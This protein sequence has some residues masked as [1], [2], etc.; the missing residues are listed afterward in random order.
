MT[1]TPI[2]VHTD[3]SNNGSMKDSIN[4]VDTLIKRMKSIGITS[5]AVTDHG[6]MSNVVNAYK[7]SAKAGIK[8]IPGY[9]GYLTADLSIQQRD[10]QHITLWAKDNIGYRNLNVISKH[11]C[12]NNGQDPG[13]YYYKPRVDIELLRKYSEGLMVG[14]ACL[15]GWLGEEILVK[16]IDIFGKDNVFLEIHT[17]QGEGQS[18]HNELA[19]YLAK[20]YDVLPVVATDAHFAFKDDFELWKLFKNTSKEVEGNETLGNTLY[21]Q[22]VDEIKAS[23]SYLPSHIVEQAIANTNVIAEKSNV[24]IDFSSKHYPHFP[25]DDE[26]EAVRGKCKDKWQSIVD[27]GLD[28][29]VYGE[30][31]KGEL[32]VLRYQDYCG[33]FLITGDYME[34]A[35]SKGIPLGPGRGSACGS[36]VAKLCNITKLD[37]VALDLTF[38]RFAHN[39]RLAPPDIDVDITPNGRS[40]I[41]EYLREKYGE[42]YQ[43]RTFGT[44]ACSGA[45]RL[46]GKSLGLDNNY[47]D[48]VAKSLTKYESDDEDDDI[49]SYDQK[50]WQLDHIRTEEN[51]E[52]IDIA[53]RF[54]GICVGYGK[55]AS[56]VIILDK[57]IDDFCAI[58]RQ[59]DSK[60]KQPTYIAACEYP[61]LEAQGLMKA[62]LLG[63]KAL[64]VIDD[65]VKAVGG[66]DIDAIPLDDPKTSAMLCEGFTQACFQIES[67][68]M[69]HLVKQIRPQSFYDLI[70]LVAL[71]RPGPLNAIVEPIANTDTLRKQHSE[72]LEQWIS[73][74]KTS[75]ES[76]Q[77][78]A[79]RWNQW[80][81]NGGTLSP[82]DVKKY[83]M[84]QT[85]IGV[86]NWTELKQWTNKGNTMESWEHWDAVI[87]DELIEPTYLYES[88]RSILEPTYSIVL[89]QE[90]IMEIAKQL[91]G[92]TLGEAD[93]L[94]RI[95]GKKKVDEM[96]PALNAMI[97]RGVNN[98]IPKDVMEAIATQIVEFAMYCFNKCMAGDERLHRPANGSFVP[99][100]KEMWLIKNDKEYAKSTGHKDLHSKYNTYGY[101]TTLSMFDDGNI[102]KN[103]VIDI[104]PSGEAAIYRVTTATGKVVDCTMNHKFPTP[105]GERVLY[106][107]A[108]GDSLYVIGDYEITAKIYNFYNS[109]PPPSN[110]PTAG[111]QG[112]Q[113]NPYG[114]SALFDTAREFYAT[115]KAP[116]EDCGTGTARKYE[117]HHVNMNRQDNSN[118]NLRWLCVSCHRKTHYAMGRTK[119]GTRGS[120]AVI[121]TIT[122][123]EYLRTD[124]VFDVTMDAPNH[125]FVN[126]GGVV[127][128]NSHSAAYG[129]LAYQTAHLKANYQREYLCAMINSEDNSHKDIIPYIKECKKLGIA[130]LPPDITKLNREWAIEG[131]GL[132]MGLHYIKGVGDN[133]RLDDVSSYEAVKSLNNKGVCAAL[134]KSGALD[135]FGMSRLSMLV[136]VMQTQQGITKAYSAV[137]KNHKA[138]QRLTADNAARTTEVQRNTKVYAE[139]QRKIEKYTKDIPRLQSKLEEAKQIHRSLDSFNDTIGEV[140]VLGY[141][142]GIAPNVKVGK[143]TNVYSKVVSNG[144]TMGWVT[145]KSDYGEFRCSAFEDHWLTFKDLITV[146]ASYLF[147]CKETAF[148]YNLVE[149]SVNGKVYAAPKRSYGKR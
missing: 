6:T 111:Q 23:L 76:K 47:V 33:Y 104:V 131:N 98:G 90:Q 53:K 45:I 87:V 44:M 82:N 108:V 140:E 106:D 68:G 13:N 149:L 80:K 139:N 16:F 65:T 105:K 121:D 126:L 28:T 29:K 141:S 41:I 99:T 133:L 123:I 61:L 112:F 113:R 39:A 24:I 101:G 54:V 75:G 32:E 14:S 138:I 118:E 2:H 56:A 18:K 79:K 95:I 36:Y 122:S 109:N 135:C 5:W 117:L 55:H 20:K 136:D 22:D 49:S 92:Y 73:E 148:G 4:K 77:S 3:R 89:Y 15:G 72:A 124:E 12:G 85:Y 26:Y 74:N 52:L 128:C 146:G 37:S 34:H 58:E 66:I 127:V 19:L 59:V 83:T 142:E 93:N 1:Y 96:K 38:E 8:L 114:A 42:V 70:P 107:L 129:L 143:L 43:V 50:M 51:S 119:V 10:L 125:N 7:A 100:L 17:Y 120:S 130:V 88:L 102:K 35:A 21:I 71:Y 67:P 48:S 25:C 86:K 62:D 63:L 137:T 132:R 46:A 94:R 97:E 115:M 64:Q 60:T 116:C 144:S 30:R 147:V 78:T 27:S 81:W 57:D 84:V 11:A 110:V 103:K 69:T 40:V 9:E 134:A 31:I 91:C 145:L